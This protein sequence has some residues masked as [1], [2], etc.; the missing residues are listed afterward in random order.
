MLALKENHATGAAHL[1]FVQAVTAR[2]F[3]KS[4]TE[5]GTMAV[6]MIST[7]KISIADFVMA[8]VNARIAMDLV[9]AGNVTARDI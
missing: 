3:V 1:E 7:R 2:E 4:A 5:L 8:L 9:S 6:I